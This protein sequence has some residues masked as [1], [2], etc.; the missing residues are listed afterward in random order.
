VEEGSGIVLQ[1]RQLGLNVPIIGGNG[2]NSPSLIKNAG[3]AAEGVLIGAAWHSSSSQPMNKKFVADFTAKYGNP[4]DQFAA[5]AF[6]G[7]QIACAAIKKAGS[8]N[9]KAIRDAL[10]KTKNLDTVLGKYS[11]TAGR[12]ADYTP[13]VQIVKNGKFVVLGE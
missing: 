6:A 2:F 3:S 1:A 8:T 11:F 5:Q 9:H 7:V 12:D 10:A 13:I 4:P